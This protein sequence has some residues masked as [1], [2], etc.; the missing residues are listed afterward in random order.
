MVLIIVVLGNLAFSSARQ[1]FT[2]SVQISK[3]YFWNKTKLRSKMIRVN[4]V[5][6]L[7]A[8]DTILRRARKADMQVLVYIAPIRRDVPIPY[9]LIEYS[10]FKADIENI[11][12][13]HGVKLADYED[14]VPGPLWGMKDA[15]SLGGE[16][17]LDFAF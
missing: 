11:S 15:T 12:A 16:K 5:R 13:E 9:D 6:N 1:N 17:E 4:Y 8:F 7:E 3:L 2:L 10:K 14:I